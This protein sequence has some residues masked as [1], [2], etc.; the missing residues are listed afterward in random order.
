MLEICDNVDVG[1]TM[2]QREELESSISVGYDGSLSARARIVLLWD[3]KRG[4]ESIAKELGTT[5]P[6]VYKWVK[7]YRAG[8]LAALENEKSPGRPRE[9]SDRDRARIVALTKMSPPAETGLTHWSTYQM[10]KYLKRHQGID[11]SHNFVAQLWREHGLKPH[12]QGTFKMSKDPDF[13]VKVADIIGLYLDPPAGAVVLSIDEKTQVQ[14]LQRTQ[15]LLPMSFGKTEKRTHDY[16]RH[17]TTNL[18]AALDTL[19][20]QVIGTCFPR[21]RTGEFL[22]FIDKVVKAYPD[23]PEIHVILDNL[24]THSSP[25]VDTWLGKHPNVTF[26]FTPTG[27]SWIN[28]IETWF[29]IITRQ[30]IRRGNFASLTQ[31]IRQIDDYIAHWN[32]SAGPFQWKATADQI[33]E[34]VAILERDYRKLLANNTK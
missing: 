23:G 15:P 6:T 29:G 24:S 25:D 10:A 11:V 1:L 16:L 5:K 13:A 7:R 27:S 30:S 21:R 20:G 22:K 4:A 3:E 28:Q 33:L 34:K 26:H 14:A 19:T 2:E 12:R 31:L 32:E 17:G 9:V 8:G 18:F